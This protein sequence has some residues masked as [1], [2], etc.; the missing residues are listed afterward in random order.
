MSY[1]DLLHECRSFINER[2][3]IEKI[4]V[5][6]KVKI[7]TKKWKIDSSPITDEEIKECYEDHRDRR[8]S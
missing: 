8:D 6:P 1:L 2:V 7:D 5:H 4:K 3:R